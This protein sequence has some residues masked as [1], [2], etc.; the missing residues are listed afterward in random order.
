MKKTLLLIAVLACTGVVAQEDEIWACQGT[1]SNG[2][3]FRNGSWE[4]ISYLPQNFRVTLLDG[5]AVINNLAI[6]ETQVMS[7][8]QQKEQRN[9]VSFLHCS[10]QLE[11]PN[12]FSLNKITGKAVH[13][14]T[15]SYFSNDMNGAHN[16][17]VSLFQ[18]TKF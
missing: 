10:V 2:F 4:A 5:F 9:Y 18:C 6:D 16:M 12:N 14:N 7:C 3:I 8:E 17:Y 15:L 13:S 1:E 11:N